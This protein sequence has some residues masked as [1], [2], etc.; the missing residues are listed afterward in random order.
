MHGTVSIFV[1]M[2][3]KRQPF[4]IGE[5]PLSGTINVT[6]KN[7]HAICKVTPSTC[8][9]GK[10][11]LNH[12]ALDSNPARNNFFNS[13]GTFLH[14]KYMYIYFFKLVHCGQMLWRLFYKLMVLDSILVPISSPC[15][16]LFPWGTIGWHSLVFLSKMTTKN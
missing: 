13:L 2:H 8:L 11:T 16:S 4:C 7:L 9:V 15:I 5:F 12:K 10:V 1:V 3:R 6:N 14:S